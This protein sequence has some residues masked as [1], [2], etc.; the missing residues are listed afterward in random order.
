MIHGEYNVNLLN[1]F[2]DDLKKKDSI[3][4]RRIGSSITGMQVAM[5]ELNELGYELL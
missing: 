3:W 5:A 1:R 2:I 4:P